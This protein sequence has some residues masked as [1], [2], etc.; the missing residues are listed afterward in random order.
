VGS[1]V[2]SGSTGAGTSAVVSSTGRLV[3][4]VFPFGVELHEIGCRA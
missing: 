3:I 2:G 1:G 4:G